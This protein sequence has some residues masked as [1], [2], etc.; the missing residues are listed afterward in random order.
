MG[1][2]PNPTT[3]D[4]TLSMTLPERADIRIS[5]VNLLGKEVQTQV[6]S[7]PAGQQQQT[8][9]LDALPTG[10]YIIS[11]QAQGEIISRKVVKE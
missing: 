11:L 8:L 3:G 5:V 6:L 2:S 7:L 9:S 10:I 4:I 1:L